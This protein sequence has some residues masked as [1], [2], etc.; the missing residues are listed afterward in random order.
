[1]SQEPVSESSNSSGNL[2]RDVI[3][4]RMLS[5]YAWQ[6]ATKAIIQTSSW[7]ST[8]WVAR[9]LVP[10][11]YGIMAIAGVF[12]GLAF[13]VSE[14]GL[15]EGLIARRSAG[16]DAQESVFT[17]G[18][19]LSVLMY[20]TLYLSA[21]TIAALYEIPDIEQ[22][23][24]VGGLALLVGA[25]KAVP[26]ALVMR[27]LNFRY[28]SLVEMFAQLIQIIVLIWLALAGF[29]YWSLVWAFLAGQIVTAVAFWPLYTRFPRLR[30]LDAK[31]IEV[32]KFG[33]KL[34]LNRLSFFTLQESPSAIVGKMLGSSVVGFYNMAYQLAI[35]PIEKIASVFNQ[36]TFPA[37]ASANPD[38]SDDAKYL[39]LQ[40]HKYV[41][42]IAL[43]ALVGLALVAPDLIFVLL[44][45]KWMPIV[46]AL[47]AFCVLN[48]LRLSSMIFS[49]VLLGRDKPGLV[50]RVT[51]IGLLILPVAVYFGTGF[52]LIGVVIAWSMVQPIL[53]AVGLR[54]LMRTIDMT[55]REFVTSWL[56]AAG[57]SLVMMMFVLV[58]RWLMLEATPVVRL[59][60]AIVVG[61][62][63]YLA[64][65]YTFHHGEVD[66]LKALLRSMR[67]PAS[68]KVPAA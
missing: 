51:S 66:K 6:G 19:I 52:G 15:A 23:I 43:P 8:I 22:V 18:L 67:K 11:D 53:F 14:L 68:K 60:V 36:V 62:V 59:V 46:P 17:L 33:F 65:I 50:L 39:F 61:I 30:V 57:T 29:G 12:T 41:L 9:I 40:T 38:K 27:D 34:T 5:G 25:S 56:P 45:E 3:Q 10:E 16:V 13:R 28:R 31:G 1:M 37:I 35:M 55:F 42:L 63:A 24:K 48:V 47:Q 7:V 32:A 4:K 49:P 54:Y 2:D 26:Y 64:A 20:A 21:P 44:T 58:A